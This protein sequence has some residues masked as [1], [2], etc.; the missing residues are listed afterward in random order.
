MAQI[1][2]ARW[3]WSVWSRVARA[4]P[5]T[6]TRASRSTTLRALLGSTVLVVLPVTIVL[7]L[8]FPAASALLADDAR[9]AGAASRARC[10][11]ST[12]SVRSPA[13]VLIP[14]LLIPSLG[15]PLV[16]ALLALVNAVLGVALA[17][18]E[19]RPEAGSSRSAGV[20]VALAVAVVAA[21]ARASLVQPNEA[22]ID[23]PAASS[24]RRPRTRSRR[25]RPARSRSR[26]SCGSPARR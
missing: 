17:L 7:G 4:G 14:F 6:S 22:Y 21:R 16:V 5:R 19:P 12:R 26:P 3:S 15:S 20:V 25:S 18:R 10:S 23:R 2:V 8:S 1:L 13:S 9:H 11:P 24:S